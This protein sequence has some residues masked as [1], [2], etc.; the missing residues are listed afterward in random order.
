ME[1]SQESDS[2]GPD[3]FP[4]LLMSKVGGT[5]AE[6]NGLIASRQ[7][8]CPRH[9]PQHRSLGR[10][11]VERARMAAMIPARLSLV[12]L[13]ARD[14]P[15]LRAFYEA[16]GWV[17][18]PGSGDDFASFLLGGV[19]LALYPGELLRGEA[20]PDLAPPVPGSWNGITL[21]LNVDD[22]A[23]VDEVFAGAVEAGARPVS[24]PVDREWGGRSGYI[25]DPEENRWEIAWAP[26]TRFNEAG[27]VIDS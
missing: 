14:L 18:R 15:R 23:Q 3:F 11:V 13:G 25:A 1:L 21:A 12:T 17:P 27:A 4:W 9:H 22:R 5:G 6:Q 10:D 7:V 16:M 8:T 24:P 20:A 2:T 19:L 26:W